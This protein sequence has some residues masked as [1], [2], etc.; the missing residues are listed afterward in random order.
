MNVEESQLQFP[1][2]LLQVGEDARIVDVA[3]ES[4]RVHQLA[5]IGLRIGTT[6]RMIQA[7]SPC[8]LAIDGRRLSVRL[9]D[10]DILVSSHVNTR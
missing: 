5:E 7:G 3:A 9:E 10:V 2:D 6:V 1:L 4:V 8:I